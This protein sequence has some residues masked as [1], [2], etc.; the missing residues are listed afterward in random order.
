M[1]TLLKMFNFFF[2]SKI[3]PL[4]KIDINLL[5]KAKREEDGTTSI[6]V[7]SQVTVEDF[8]RTFICFCQF[9]NLLLL[10]VCEGLQPCGTYPLK[11]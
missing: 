11:N 10:C 5:F 3:N 1:T 6:Y 2:S 9:I 7:P 4:K 8:H